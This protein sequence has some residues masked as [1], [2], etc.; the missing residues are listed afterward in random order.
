[1][2]HIKKHSMKLFS[3]EKQ[4]QVAQLQFTLKLSDV[5]FRIINMNKKPD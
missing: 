3:A 4:N 5:F 2:K 1:M